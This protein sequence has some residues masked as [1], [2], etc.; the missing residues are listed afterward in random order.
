[1]KVDNEIRIG[2]EIFG[3]ANQLKRKIGKESAEYGVTSIQ[4]RIIGFVNWQSSKR[5]IFQKDIEAEFNIRR[6][7]VTSVLKLMEKN[8]L[9]ER[10]SVS[11][12]ARL[13]K[14]IL[15]EKGLEV[16]KHVHNFID[17]MENELKDEFTDIELD[18]FMDLVNR[19]SK[20]I[21]D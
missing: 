4:G 9:I 14:I 7:S 20:K 5:D 15:T 18:M 11:E 1:M 6:S 21:G 2:R 19:L 10:V 3:L 12:D 13:K 16:D 8:E 17:D